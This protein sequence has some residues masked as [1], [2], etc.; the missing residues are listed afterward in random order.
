MSWVLCFF[1]VFPSTFGVK[2]SFGNLKVSDNSLDDAHPYYWI[3]DM[4]DP[5]GSSFVQVQYIVIVVNSWLDV[6]FWETELW[7]NKEE[8]VT[9]FE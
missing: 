1:Q 9:T 4:R 3:C 7:E 5:G 2:A 8:E 6:F